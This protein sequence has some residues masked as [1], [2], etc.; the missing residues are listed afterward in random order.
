MK[1]TVFLLILFENKDILFFKWM[2][3]EGAQEQPISGAPS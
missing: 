2:E 1:Y 3:M